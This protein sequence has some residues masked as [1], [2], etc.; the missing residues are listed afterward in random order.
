MIINN[1][2][3]LNNMVNETFGNLTSTA[4]SPTKIQH[5]Q[6]LT[7]N[8]MPKIE[9]ISNDIVTN[10]PPL[11][12][13]PSASSSPSP[14]SI[15]QQYQQFQKTHHA[16][17]LLNQ[18]LNFDFFANNLTRNTTAHPP[19]YNSQSN[20]QVPITSSSSSS[21]ATPTTTYNNTNGNLYTPTTNGTNNS[22]NNTDNLNSFGSNLN[23]LASY[24]TNE[25]FYPFTNTNHSTGYQQYHQQYTD[26]NSSSSIQDPYNRQCINNTLPVTQN[27]YQQQSKPLTQ[28]NNTFNYSNILQP[29]QN[30]IQSHYNLIP[31]QEDQ[32]QQL[33][34][35]QSS[36]KT[37]SNKALES[38][39]SSSSSSSSST[40]SSTSLCVL[41]NINANSND[42]LRQHQ[43]HH[44]Q[45]NSQEHHEESE[46]EEDE[47]DDDEH[48]ESGSNKKPPV[49]YAWMKKVHIAN[50]GKFDN[51]LI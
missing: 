36:I 11:T 32:Q 14:L 7:I 13:S 20:A 22:N 10:S 35:L 4:Q 34:N 37:N 49:I 27:S 1:M 41:G 9:Q 16:N 33:I 18:N 8:R 38:P 17:Y 19:Q 26:S 43:Q 44:Q 40:I 51:F 30:T 29:V 47:E 3:H 42:Q 24:N 50:P 6:Y 45:Q 23:Y 5:Q 31:C 48:P 28:L 15:T 46:D 39:S 12:A 2:N 21:T 25:F